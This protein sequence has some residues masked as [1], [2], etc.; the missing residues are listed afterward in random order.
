M[1]RSSA[2]ATAAATPPPA[3][4]T[5]TEATCAD[6][7]NVVADMITAAAAPKCDARASTPNDAPSAK[8][9]GT[10]GAARR[11]P[12]RMSLPEDARLLPVAA[13]AHLAPLAR[14][15]ARIVDERPTAGVGAAR[16]QPLPAPVG[17]RVGDRR[18]HGAERAAHPALARLEADRVACEADGEAGAAARSVERRGGSGL[19][20]GDAVVR[21]QQL[22]ESLAYGAGLLGVGRPCADVLSRE[23]MLREPAYE[24][25]RVEQ[26]VAPPLEVGGVH[27][28]PDQ[29]QIGHQHP[30]LTSIVTSQ[31]GISGYQTRRRT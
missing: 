2:A 19:V 26:V 6:P 5:E 8:T 3:P 24:A 13:D 15:V 11:T 16:L 18:K 25:A 1:F 12:L 31:Y 20:D 23:T 21:A 4:S 14:P 7:A 17:H 10:N 30:H 28:V 27:E 29:F 9:A 22:A